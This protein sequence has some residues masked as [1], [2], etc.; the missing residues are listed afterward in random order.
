MGFMMNLDFNSK[1]NSA[2]AIVAQWV[3]FQKEGDFEAP[4]HAILCAVQPSVNPNRVEVANFP[5]FFDFDYN[6]KPS[7]AD[8][9]EAFN[10]YRMWEDP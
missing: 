7:T 3:Q 10:T 4:K 2:E 9:L 6:S 8:F 5:G 1:L